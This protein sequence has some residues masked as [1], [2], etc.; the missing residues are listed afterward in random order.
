LPWAWARHL[1]GPFSPAMVF[2]SRYLIHEMLLVFFTALTLGRGLA[3]CSGRASSRRR[4]SPSPLNGERAGVRGGEVPG[5]ARS[6]GTVNTVPTPHPQSLSPLRGEGSQRSA[7][8]V[9]TGIGLG[10]DVHDEGDFRHHRRRDGNS[11]EI[12]TAWWT[13]ARRLRVPRPARAL[14]TGKHAALA[15]G[16]GL[17]HLATAFQF[18][19]HPL[20]RLAGFGRAPIC[21][22]L[23]RRRA[24]IPPHIHPWYF[25]LPAAR[26]VFIRAKGPGLE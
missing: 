20:R 17:H 7:W 21:P 10:P 26:L 19:L 5:A 22:G 25:Y 12:A 8:A 14:G 16:G 9:M 4:F 11:Q 2:Y 13:M 15:L 1:H 6:T 3:L 24:A 23:K 18:H